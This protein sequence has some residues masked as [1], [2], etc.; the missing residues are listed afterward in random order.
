MFRFGNKDTKIMTTKVCPKCNI[1]KPIGDFWKNA[2][3]PDGLY[4][5]CKVCGLIERKEKKNTTIPN[6]IQ[7]VGRFP[8]EK[9]LNVINR[10]ISRCNHLIHTKD[11]V[12]EIVG[13]PLYTAT[14]HKIDQNKRKVL[15][16]LV[17]DY[18]KPRYAIYSENSRGITWIVK[19]HE[20]KDK[21][22]VQS[23]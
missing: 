11:I 21:T 20:T 1:K 18:M 15:A 8:D 19:Q 13:I 10:A 2:S 16:R 7:N 22:K 17:T 12:S 9:N 6:I 4:R 5:V 3:K 14:F 23:G